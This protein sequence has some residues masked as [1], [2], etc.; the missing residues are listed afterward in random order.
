MT[1]VNDFIAMDSKAQESSTNRIVKHLESDIFKKQKVDENV[2]PVI[3]DS[4]EIKKCMDI[5]PDDGDEVLIK[6]TPISYR[7][8][9]IIDNKI[10][11]EGKKNYFKIIREDDRFKKEKPVDDM[12]NILFRILKTMFEHHVEYTIWKYQQGLAK[13]DYDVKMAYDL[14]RFTRKQL[15]EALVEIKKSKPKGVTTATTTVTIPTPDSTRPKA[16]GVVMQEPSETLTTTTIPKSSKVQDKG[17][18]KLAEEKAQL[19]EDENLAWDNVQAMIDADYELAAKLQ[20]EE[21]GE[22]TIKEKSKKIMELMD[23]RKKHFAKLRA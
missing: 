3:D 4:K 22:L 19:I 23:K 20:E 17:K 13:V 21:Q 7:S 9:T 1:K 5:V 15:M 10:H 2:E 18:D 14:L 12:D 8:P 11:K 16:R 6:A